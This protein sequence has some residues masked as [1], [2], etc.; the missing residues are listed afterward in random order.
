MLIRTGSIAEFYGLIPKVPELNQN[1]TFRHYKTR[2]EGK[3]WLILIAE[4]NN[5]VCGFKVGYGIDDKIF[6]SW[7]GGVMP[8]YRRAGVAQALLDAQESWAWVN[9]FHTIKVKTSLGFPAMISFLESNEYKLH[10]SWEEAQLYSKHRPNNG[11]NRTPVS[12]A[13][14]KPVRFDGGAG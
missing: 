4:R 7:V 12:F 5:E 8:N 11:F 6:Y 14:A 1:H 10:E 3:I 9:N 13:A 2:L